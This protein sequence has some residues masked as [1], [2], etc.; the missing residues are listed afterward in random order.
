[1]KT[2]Q[3]EVSSDDT[4]P[5][6]PTPRLRLSPSSPVRRPMSSSI[7]RFPSLRR[8]DSNVSTPRFDSDQE[9]MNMIPSNR[10][11]SVQSPQ[12]SP[13]HPITDLKLVREALR[14]TPFNKVGGGFIR[15]VLYKY[16]FYYIAFFQFHQRYNKNLIDDDNQE[17][18]AHLRRR[19]TTARRISQIMLEHQ[20]TWPMPSASIGI[21]LI[22]GTSLTD[23]KLKNLPQLQKKCAKLS[24][25]TFSMNYNC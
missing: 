9:E 21:P 15:R 3:G 16:Y 1:M 18:S 22:K 13:K 25:A 5:L 17:L 11:S 8:Q 2:V 12:V 7:F 10:R 14:Q 23:G 24:L 20:D 4:A 6:L 19:H